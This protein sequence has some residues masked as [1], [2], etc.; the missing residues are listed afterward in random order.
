[1]SNQQIVN[2]LFTNRL[3]YANMITRRKGGTHMTDKG[4]AKFGDFI[5]EKRLDNNLSILELSKRANLSR[6]TIS[7]I[8]NGHIK[9]GRKAI[10]RIATA[11]GMTY[12]ELRQVM[13]RVDVE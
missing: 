9:G 13:K 10:D 12:I 3:Q 4:M 1:M 5:R 11:L 2:Y 6:V 8:E 7:L